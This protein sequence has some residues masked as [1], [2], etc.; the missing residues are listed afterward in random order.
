MPPATGFAALP[1][2]SDKGVPEWDETDRYS[3]SL[4]F[5]DVQQLIDRFAVTGNKDQKRAALLYVP[6]ELRRLW[7][8]YPEFTDDA[9][10][11]DDF[12]KAVLRFY[13]GDDA[14][15]FTLTDYHSLFASKPNGIAD[16]KEYLTFFSRFKPVV[17]YLTSLKPSVLDEN[18]A[19]T[20]LL[21]V[22]PRRLFEPVMLYLDRTVPNKTENTVYTVNQIH[23]GITHCWTESFRKQ[24]YLAVIAPGETDDASTFTAARGAGSLS[25]AQVVKQEPKPVPT[26]KEELSEALVGFRAEILSALAQ[27]ARVAEALPPR[28]PQPYAP[29]PPPPPM[30]YGPP[31][32]QGGFGGPRMYPPRICYYCGNQGCHSN[33]CPARWAQDRFA[34]AFVSGMRSTPTSAPRDRSIPCYSRSARTFK[35]STTSSPRPNS[36][37]HML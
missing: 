12:R 4:Y 22:V 16:Y 20:K 27:G 9:K 25:P 28:Q 26:I 14:N 18:H 10:G 21:S 19:A 33:Y 1:L 30:N 37:T 29:A 11:F 6:T 5:D 13:A 15:K 7:S 24:G 23:E 34:S 8:T 3:V 17:N 31:P 2:R 36:N 35:T 32:P